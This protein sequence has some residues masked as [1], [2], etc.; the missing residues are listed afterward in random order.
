MRRTLTLLFLLTAGSTVAQTVTGFKGIIT[1]KQSGE[2]L[3]GATVKLKGA[4]Y[5]SA[6]TTGL[7]GS[8]LFKNIPEGDYEL[9]VKDMGHHE[10]EQHVHCNKGQ[11]LTLQLAMDTRDVSLQTHTVKG[12]GDKGNEQAAL[13]SIQ[14]ADQLLNTVS[15]NAIQLSPDITIANVMQRVS[16]VSLERSN[17]G[18]GQYAIIRG[19]D[20]RYQYTLINGVKIPS[21]DNKN[22]YVPLDI[23][24]ADLV[25]RLEVYKT[26][27]PAM[28]ADAIGGATNMVMKDAPNRFVLNANAAIGYA[29]TLFNN[30][31]PR[32]DRSASSK[33]SPRISNGN[34]Y[35]ANI[36]DFPNN[37]LHYTTGKAPLSSVFGLS[38]GGR[39]RN[40]KLGGI[41]GIS[42]QNT[43]RY[44]EGLFLSTEVDRTT[45][46]PAF[47][48]AESR[49]YAIQ[50]Q[51]LGLHGKADYQFND[52]QQ[53]SLYAAYMNLGQN[54]FRF[55]SDTSLELGRTG[56]GSG[57][58]S[59]QYRSER[60]VNEI[61][62]ITLHGDH[63]LARH[64]HMNWSAV[65]S[66]ATANLPDRTELKL[67]T[68]VTKQKD[69]SLQ[70]EP[71]LLDALNGVTHEWARN[72]DEDKSAYLNFIYSPRIAG[73]KTEI[74]AGGMYR[75]KQRRS[76]YDEY[77]LRPDSTTQQFFNDIDKHTL[78][79]FTRL[80]TFDNALNYHFTE[81]VG[82]YY[83][84]VKF[85]T[86]RLQTLAGVRVE[87]TSESWRSDVSELVA[88]KTGSIKY[89]DVMP[90]LHLKYSPDQRQNIRL[91]YYSA[92]SRPGFYE[93]IPHIG[94][95]PEA[96]YTEKGNP[97]LK[98]A[99]SDNFD[100]RYEFFPKGLDQL[101][102]GIFYK[103][104]QNPIEAALVQE[105]RNI[106]FMS[107]N[108]GTATNYGLEVDVAKY[109]RKFGV[110]ANYTY[111][112]SSISSNK[113]LW[114]RQEDGNVT[115]KTV[116]QT[117]P[118]QGQSRHVANFSL[119]YKDTKSGTDA[120][121]A[122]VYTGERIDKVSPYLDNDI[123]QKSFVQLDLSLQQKIW[124]NL[125]LY[126]KVGNLLNTPYELFIKHKNDDNK[127]G[128]P[129][130]ETGKNILVRK[131]TYGQ[132]Y[133]LGLRF[134]I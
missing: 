106:Y 9:K 10:I 8:F 115:Q 129:H 88:G 65:W 53:I 44:N 6:G 103:R 91:S 90:S 79:V 26:L 72:K 24:P 31:Y 73:I 98:R 12:K 11:L 59:N 102:A 105:G 111:T 30:D 97:N 75:D 32:F 52:D 101:L 95:D 133:L 37:P 109:I 71:V 22:R 78:S 66:S 121:L 64:L 36:K 51:R 58:I 61:A 107:N 67:T 39:S 110:R 45:N 125:S 29:Q 83:A 15:A 96:D 43:Y 42:Y 2:P 99:T 13:K 116:S 55:S 18:D 100:L 68:G 114:F 20:K 34:S 122:M 104:I 127:A 74:S 70:Q 120:Q 112:N 94:G 92:I 5:A 33:L 57:R 47:T 60:T 4:Q 14:K 89:Y 46:Q 27:T 1:D 3:V 134:K 76:N 118:L 41:A 132:T 119:L 54:L 38:L 62:N 50:Q 23:F 113:A 87:H 16:G 63:K 108:F 19:M 77:A 21:P 49:Q 128:V 93:V 85:S 25:D 48:A 17:N 7:D 80:G 69:N 131:S 56:P 28:E 81:K 82:A 126:A 40:K 86:G 130:Q 124:K 117:R 84:Q 35:E 123:W